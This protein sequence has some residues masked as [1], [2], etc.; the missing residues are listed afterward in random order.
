MFWEPPREEEL[1]WKPPQSD[2]D[3]DGYKRIHAL[4]NELHQM[5]ITITQIYRELTEGTD[6]CTKIKRL[7]DKKNTEELQ[8]KEVLD[9]VNK[10]RIKS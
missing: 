4:E 7:K 1:E 6:I 8:M 5:R 9:L 3:K 2:L 10:S